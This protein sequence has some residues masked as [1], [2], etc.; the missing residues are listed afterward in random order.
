MTV[1]LTIEDHGAINIHGYNTAGQG[2]PLVYRSGSVVRQTCVQ[3]PVLPL[4][5]CVTLS[6]LLKLSCLHFLICGKA[7]NPHFI[8]LFYK[9]MRVKRFTKCQAR[10]K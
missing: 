4:H 3:D 6:K 9:L 10:S 8:G 5:S 7:N 2:F 1:S